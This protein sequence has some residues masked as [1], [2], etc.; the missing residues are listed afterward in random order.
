MQHNPMIAVSKFG[1]RR[2]GSSRL[3]FANRSRTLLEVLFSDDS[4]E[5]AALPDPINSLPSATSWS[6]DGAHITASNAT[7]NKGFVFIAAVIAR[8]SWT[9]EISLV[10][11]ENTVEVAVS[12]PSSTVGVAMNSNRAIRHTILTYSSVIQQLQSLL[13][14]SAL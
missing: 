7:N 2:T 5:S 8:N 6:P 1:A 13:Q 4:G 9:S 3:R 10:G 11:H 12:V 14:T